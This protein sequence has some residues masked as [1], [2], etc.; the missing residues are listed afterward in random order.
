M[1]EAGMRRLFVLLMALLLAGAG[2]AAAAPT[3][4]PGDSVLRV[5]AKFQ[6]QA[7]KPFT[8]AQRRGGVQLVTMFYSSCPYA[9]PLIIDTGKG[10]DHALSPGERAKLRVLLLSL[11]PK[12]DTPA[13]LAAL[14]TKRKIDNARWTLGTSDEAGV[15]QTAAALG[16][17]YRQLANGEFNHS[18]V[19]IL[20]DADGRILARTEKIGP[21]PDPDFVAAVKKALRG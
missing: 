11:D 7:G 18:S 19:M 6:D 16:I 20:L 1:K 14:S 4:L 8:L 21:Q 5:T 9:C 17:R 15:R 13:K 2:T 10:I 3:A 12:R